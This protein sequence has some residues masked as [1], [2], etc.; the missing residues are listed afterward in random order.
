MTIAQAINSITM[1][2]GIEVLSSPNKVQSMVQDYVKGYERE[3]KIFYRA[4]QEGILSYAQDILKLKD[5][6]KRMDIAKKAKERLEYHAFMSEEYAILSVNMILDG[7]G[8]KMKLVSERTPQHKI[9]DSGEQWDDYEILLSNS[10]IYK[11]NKL[12]KLMN[13]AKYGNVQALIDLGGCYEHGIGVEADWKIAE[14]F[15]RL[16]EEAGSQEAECKRIKLRI[17]ISAIDGENKFF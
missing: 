17:L 16:A 3:K 2:Y 7:I 1:N 12:Q 14:T 5:D 10:K 15:Y 8:L 11:N 9:Y 13:A 4:C 6:I